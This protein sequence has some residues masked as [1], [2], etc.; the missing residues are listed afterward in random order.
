MNFIEL[1]GRVGFALLLTIAMVVAGLVLAT[2]V[3]DLLRLL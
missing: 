1:L 3:V 2:L